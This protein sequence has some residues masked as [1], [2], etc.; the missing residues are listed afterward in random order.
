MG[1]LLRQQPHQL[2]NVVEATS[3]H[4]SASTSPHPWLRQSDVSMALLA[5]PISCDWHPLYRAFFSD[6]MLSRQVHV[7]VVLWD[8]SFDMLLLHVGSAF[9][10]STGGIRFLSVVF[11][12]ECFSKAC[13]HSLVCKQLHPCVVMD[14]VSLSTWQHVFLVLLC[15]VH[16]SRNEA[17]LPW[18]FLAFSQQLR[19]SVW[20]WWASVCFWEIS[21]PVPCHVFG[22]LVCLLRCKSCLCD[23]KTGPQSRTGFR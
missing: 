11:M 1:P 15:V 22:R 5:L 20:T 8:T 4:Q 18:S 16:P 6:G 2:Q 7:I 13:F 14:T 17:V 21:I 19:V 9:V 12:Y 10:Y 3:V 23:L